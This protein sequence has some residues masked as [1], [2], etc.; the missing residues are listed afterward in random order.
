MNNNLGFQKLSCE[1]FQQASYTEMVKDPESILSLIELMWNAP[2]EQ[3][4]SISGQGE[5]RMN[6]TWTPYQIYCEILKKNA[7]V[8]RNYKAF[9]ELPFGEVLLIL[10]EELRQI[11]SQDALGMRDVL[12]RIVILHHDFSDFF[13]DE[14]EEG[15]S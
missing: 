8:P 5:N 1:Q 15:W 12:R 11:P 7:S 10:K 13:D 6:N 9:A 14:D 2:F 4:Y 3:V